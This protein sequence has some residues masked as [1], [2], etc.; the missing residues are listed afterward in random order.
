MSGG[1][2]SRIYLSGIHPGQ[3]PSLFIQSVMLTSSLSTITSSVD[4]RTCGIN[5]NCWYAIARS[6]EVKTQ[7]LGITFWNHPIVLYRDNSNTVRALEDRCPHRQVKLSGG[8]IIV[9]N[10]EC[11]YHGWQFTAEGDCAVVPGLDDEQ[12]LPDCRLRQ[13]LVHEADGWIWLFPGDVE[14]AA[15]ISPLRI[16]EWDRLDYMASI[17]AIDCNAHYSFLIE[18]LMDVHHGQPLHG[19][20]QMWDSAV[21]E[22]LA[23]DGDRVEAYYQVQSYFQ[24]ASIWSLA[25][26]AFPPLRRPYPASLSVSY[27]YPH[28]IATLGEDFKTY[29]LICPVNQTTTRAYLLHFTSLSALKGFQKLPAW[30]RR[31]VRN[32]LSSSV[33]GLLDR[34]VSQDVKIVEEEQQAYLAHPRQQ[35]HESNPVL[36]SVQQLIWHQAM[37]E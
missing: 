13:Y 12:P 35:G 31:P 1:M 3:L 25:Q 15:S 22:K 16:P 19:N 20:C 27:R 30:V 23:D 5:P 32:R 34:F 29:G 14:K 8:R 21:L 7:P 36:P 6:S 26:L 2:R 24:V 18:N 33:Q 4:L 37:Q 10:L 17:T 28:W 9:D 11:P